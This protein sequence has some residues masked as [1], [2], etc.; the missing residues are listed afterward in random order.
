MADTTC[1]MSISLDSV[2][3]AEPDQ[4]R[5]DPLGKRGPRK[6]HGWHLGDERVTFSGGRSTG[7]PQGHASSASTQRESL[8]AERPAARKT[9]TPMSST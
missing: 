3:V 4:S 2:F 8:T 1:H 9:P 7:A 5:E 6:L